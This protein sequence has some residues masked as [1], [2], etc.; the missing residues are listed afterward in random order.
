MSETDSSDEGE[1]TRGVFLWRHVRM[2]VTGVRGMRGV[3]GE[4]SRL[5]R[6]VNY[7]AA[8]C[9]HARC[10][11]IRN[12][13]LPYVPRAQL[14]PTHRKKNYAQAR[15]KST[16]WMSEAR[17]GS[18]TLRTERFGI[19]LC[20]PLWCLNSRGTAPSVNSTVFLVQHS[21][22]YSLQN[23]SL[24]GCGVSSESTYRK[25]YGK[26]SVVLHVLPS[27]GSTCILVMTATISTRS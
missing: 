22:R 15:L 9:E 17:G 10:V 1:P 11:S 12:T 13:R 7:L 21:R 23:V 14:W 27:I 26:L 5:Q 20:S 24:R 3:L 25:R 8:R 16:P 18:E 6:T 4:G 2:V 19:N